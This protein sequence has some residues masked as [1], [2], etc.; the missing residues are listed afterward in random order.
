MAET[1]FVAMKDHFW[2]TCVDNEEKE[3]IFRDYTETKAFLKCFVYLWYDRFKT[4][5]VKHGKQYY[6]TSL[7]FAKP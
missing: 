6:T 3:K 2:L 7:R 5:Q 1:L 4:N